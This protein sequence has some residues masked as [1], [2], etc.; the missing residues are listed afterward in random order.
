M[1]KILR[2]HEIEEED[3][4]PAH[5]IDVPDHTGNQSSSDESQ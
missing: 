4:S 2:T 3:D 5:V 1:D